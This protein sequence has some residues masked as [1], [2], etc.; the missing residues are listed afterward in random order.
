[1]AYCRSMSKSPDRGGAAD[2]VGG[3]TLEGLLA[4]VGVAF[5][6]LGAG[7]QWVAKKLREEWERNGST[8]LLA[9]E[10]T[11]GRTREE[12][13]AEITEDPRLVPLVTRLLHAAG[14]NGHD[15]TLRAMGAAFG[16]AVRERDSIDECELILTSLTDLNEKHTRTLL[17]LSKEPPARADGSDGFW[18]PMDLEQHSELS[19]RI[20]AL[21][22]ATLVARGLAAA[23]TGLGVGLHYKITSLGEVVLAVLSKYS[24]VAD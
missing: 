19:P 6:G 14:M 8:A 17:L 9:A 10:Y 11:S 4:V 15:S 5:P 12:L 24:E 3:T 16:D 20:T 22:V 18:F 2:K 23:S 13:A 7:S 1:M 21:C